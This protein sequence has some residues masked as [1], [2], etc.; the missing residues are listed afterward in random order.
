MKTI[1]ILI[2]LLLFISCEKL[3]DEYD[4]RLNTTYTVITDCYGFVAEYTMACNNSQSCII[5]KDTF[6]QFK[7]EQGTHI[8]KPP[9]LNI[10]LLC[11]GDIKAS[12]LHEGIIVSDSC[13]SYGCEIK[14][15]IN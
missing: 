3:T 1:S 10:K 7:W 13:N 5:R 4:H 6:Y 9:R 15:N 8:D 12:I 11:T 14:L 2:L